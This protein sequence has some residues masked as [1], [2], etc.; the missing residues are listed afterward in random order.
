MCWTACALQTV[1][2]W[3]N[4]GGLGRLNLKPTIKCSLENFLRLL[5]FT[6]M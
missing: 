3:S 4:F 1:S 2:M 5:Y 6:K